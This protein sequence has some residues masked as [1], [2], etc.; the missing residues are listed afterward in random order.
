MD[1]PR[2]SDIIGDMALCL[3]FFTRI[4]CQV[5]S[6]DRR[7]ADALWAVPL[8]GA[9]IGAFSG[10]AAVIALAA[11]LPPTVAALFSLGVSV[12][13]TGALHE[14]GAADTA[15]G[16]GGGKSPADALHIMRDSRIGSYGTL[17][18]IFS[19]GARWAAI[20][21]IIGVSESSWIVWAL[22]AA[23]ACSRAIIPAFAANVPPAS[24]TG[25]SAGIGKIRPVTW[26]V[27]LALGLIIALGMG[28][29]FAATTILALAACFLLIERLCRRAV[30]GQTGD[31]LGALQQL[32]EA[33]LLMVAASLL[34]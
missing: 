2:A 10:A 14:D 16:F 32:C 12:I 24:T 11:N 18:L 1:L 26:R 34:V 20:A 27:S 19:I 4:P 21:A 7:F 9:L 13:L 23:H 29:T 33:T 5:H 22:V 17:A 25:L 3:T 28:P 6:S 15:D 31:V 30:G 8:I